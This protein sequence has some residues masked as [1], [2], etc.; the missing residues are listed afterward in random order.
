MPHPHALQ[1]REVE[2]LTYRNCRTCPTQCKRNEK[3]RSPQNQTRQTD[4]QPFTPRAMEGLPRHR[5]C[6]SPPPEYHVPFSHL[7]FLIFDLPPSP[8]PPPTIPATL[9]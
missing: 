4:R 6:F 3:S 2:R 7:I 9:H 8:Q 1:Q 5:Q